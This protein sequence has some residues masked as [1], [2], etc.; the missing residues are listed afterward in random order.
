VDVDVEGDIIVWI[1][2]KSVQRYQVF[3]S[4]VSLL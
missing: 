1:F 4:K 2:V 3:S